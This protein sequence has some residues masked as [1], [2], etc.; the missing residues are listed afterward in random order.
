MRQ[1][2]HIAR[3]WRI[4]GLAV[5][6]LCGAGASVAVADIPKTIKYV[7]RTQTIPTT[8]TQSVVEGHDVVADR[9]FL[10]NGWTRYAD[11]A[12]LWRSARWL[13]RRLTPAQ[14]TCLDQLVPAE[15]ASQQYVDV[16]DCTTSPAMPDDTTITTS[17]DETYEYDDSDPLT[18]IITH[19]VTFHV[20]ETVHRIMAILR[21]DF[22]LPAVKRPP[23][24]KRGDAPLQRQKLSARHGAWYGPP[25]SF[26]YQW[27]RCDADGASNCTDL[28]DRTSRVYATKPADVGHTLRVRVTATNSEG[29]AD[30]TSAPSGVVS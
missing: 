27:V 20:T 8:T 23:T 14:R 28:P 3:H 18:L 11:A 30:A 22:T 12:G 9:S 19:T 1:P 16:D 4:L 5:V 26:A 21:H 24:I 7:E 13:E 2:R 6:A 29:S 17:T 15:G 25:T 10:D